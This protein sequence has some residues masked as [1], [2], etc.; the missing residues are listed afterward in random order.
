[1]QRALRAFEQDALAF[2]TLGVEQRP[3]RIHV[4]QNLRRQ[5][6]EIV[7]ERLG[8][9]RLESKSAAQ[10]IVVYQQTIDLAAE[11]GQVGEIHETDGAATDFVLVS[12][13]DAALGGA[14]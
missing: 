2:A 14:D 6:S 7:I 3:H 13:I 9:D 1:E 10:R 4:R 12:R 8:V 11:L 5:R